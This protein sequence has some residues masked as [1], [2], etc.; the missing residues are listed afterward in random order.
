MK[1]RIK[2]AFK[3]PMLIVLALIII[4]FTPQAIYSPGQNR[5]VGVVV[6]IGVDKKDDEFEIS[7]LTFIPTAQQ[8][9]EQMNSVI[10][11]KGETIA[12]ALYN[13]QI[14]MGRKVGL[15]HAKTTIVNQELMQNDV[16]QRKYCR[17]QSA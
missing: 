8:S 14:A 2:N 4:I 11:G 7:L 6:G 5:D 9:F 1:K 10:S 15:S 17:R 13:A 12:K 16:A 3:N